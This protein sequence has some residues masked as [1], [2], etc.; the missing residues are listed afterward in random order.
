MREILFKA[1]T[2]I[3]ENKNHAFNN[4]WVEGNLIISV[5]KYYIHPIANKVDVKGELG[6]III[7]HEII[8][9]TICQYTGLKDKQGNKIWENDIVK[10]GRNMIVAWDD[11]FASWCLTR[12][13]WLCKHFF[14][15]SREP[16][17]CE[18]IGNIFDHTDLLEG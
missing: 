17:D 10:C 1:K 2:T 11:H 4:V 13:G 14:G 12:K 15:G 9:D 5:G 8:P 7:M 3:K 16:E 18:V 6:K